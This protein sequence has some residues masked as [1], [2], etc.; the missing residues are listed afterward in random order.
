MLQN[1]SFRLEEDS[2]EAA[3]YILCLA[4]NFSKDSSF[5]RAGRKYSNNEHNQGAVKMHGYV[6]RHMVKYG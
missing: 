3:N 1:T 4:A 2:T 5:R 6:W